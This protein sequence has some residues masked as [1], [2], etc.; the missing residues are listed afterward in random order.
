MKKVL[1]FPC[2]SEVGLEIYRSLFGSTHFELLGASSVDDHG[3]FVYKNYIGGLP[4]VEDNTFISAI[5]KVVE[6]EKIDFIVPSHDSVVLKLAQAADANELAC[7]L[8]TSQLKTCEICRSKAKTYQY[9][10]NTVAVPKVFKS[11]GDVT[12]NDLPVFLKPDVGQGSK[13]THLAKT[14]KEIEFYLAENPTL[15]ILEYLPGTEYTIDCFTDKYGKLRYAGARQRNRIQNGISVNTT[16]AHDKEFEILAETINKKLSFRGAWFFQV[17]K[18]KDDIYVLMEIAPR[19]AGAM[20]FTRVKGVNLVLLSLFDRLEGIEITIIEN[21]Y[22]LTM[23]RAL[24]NIYKHNMSYKHVYLD[25]DDLVILNSKV[26]PRVMALVYQCINNGIKVHLLTKHKENI[27]HS[28]KKYRL[29]GVFDEVIW[30]KTDAEKPKHI[31]EKESIF[32]DDSFAERRSVY[33]EL[34]IPVFDAHM[35]EGLM[36]KN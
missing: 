4:Q 11:A 23:D 34:R 27:E 18:N 25:F 32:I 15:L 20:G 36:E 2:G 31:L 29:E 12:D 17:K 8:V 19:I 16:S 30:I 7:E 24:E 26:N 28:L 22:E 1:V 6:I 3:K 14:R 33:E 10:S 21:D 9:F 13:G 5:N 35:I